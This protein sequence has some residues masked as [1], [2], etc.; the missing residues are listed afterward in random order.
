MLRPSKKGNGPQEPVPFDGGT[1]DGLRKNI[2]DLHASFTSG[3]LRI[4]VGAGASQASGL[5][6]WDAL[7]RART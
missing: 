4:L 5:P 2:G 1:M 7:N 3:R 6:G